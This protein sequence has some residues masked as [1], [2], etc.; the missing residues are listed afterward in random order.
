VSANDTAVG[1]PA[2]R[3]GIVFV[4]ITVLIDMMGIGI[5]MPVMP[6]L[7][8]EL[9][10]EG[11]SQAAIYGGWLGFA[12]AVM[13]FVFAPVLGGLSDRY[14][15]RPVLL[16]AVGTLGIDYIIMGMAPTIAWLFLGRLIAGIAGAS[17][18]PAYA[19]VADITPPE[20]RAQNFG[21]ISAAFGAGFILG[22]AVGGLLAT[23][24]S[25]APFFVAAGL[26]L[27]NLL[28]GIFVLPET[29]PPER[30][31]AF[32]WRRANPAGTLL[33]MRAHPEVFALL[34]AMFLWAVAN[35]VFPSTW[36]YFT[37]LQYGW[38]EA[39][40]GASLAYVGVV[41]V[42]AQGTLPR[43]VV[44]RLG[45]YRT[46]VI[47]VISG[48]VGYSAFALATQG[49]MTFVIMLSWLLGGLALPTIQALMSH[50]VEP[51]AQG[52]LQGAV[53][54]LRSLAAI[55]GP[56]AMTQL[57]RAFTATEAPVHFPG[58]AFAFAALLAFSSLLILLSRGRAHAARSD[59]ARLQ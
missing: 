13:Q 56:P 6:A 54:S 8:M 51:E 42:T 22:P 49:W 25:R 2:S 41:M 10:G 20:K 38:T 30:R 44:P 14:G 31:R 24:G 19:Y 9:T 27:V 59:E 23:Y 29:L 5:I 4:L 32:E 18:T 12:Y 40:V 57:F 46:A 11:L 52:E 58:A 35:Q 21:L 36:A 15:R 55:V 43:L 7:I 47:A 37:M 50:R 28:Y 53:A 45:E 16:F 39:L 26:S 1:P 17:F 34:T 48:A 33:R 3:Q